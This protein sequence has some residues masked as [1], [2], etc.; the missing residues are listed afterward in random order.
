M[1][2]I[3]STT[4]FVFVG[5]VWSWDTSKDITSA[6]QVQSRVDDLQ[7]ALDIHVNKENP[8]YQF[9]D[10]TNEPVCPSMIT[11]CKT[12]YFRNVSWLESIGNATIR[13]TANVD[14]DLETR[15]D[16]GTHMAD[17][18][19][20]K[21]STMLTSTTTK[22]WK[23]GL[24]LSPATSILGLNGDVSGEYNEQYAE[25]KATT[26][27]RS[28]EKSCP[29]NMRCTIQTIT[30]EAKMPGNCFVY[31]I[32]DCGGGYDACGTF[33]T[34]PIAEKYPV[35]DILDT[36]FGPCAQF[37]DF[38]NKE[39]QRDLTKTT[40]CEITVPILDNAGKPYSHMITT[41]E[42]LQNVAARDTKKSLVGLQEDPKDAGQPPVDL[43]V[44]FVD[45]I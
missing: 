37:S 14:A 15:H 33:S 31:P 39:C 22:G 29:P 1:V 36:F 41:Q 45:D 4:L 44:E 23:V 2:A 3:R 18:V 6:Q 24:K 26:V 27:E 38:G 8:P 43:V 25:A 20:T 30:Y 28:V 11:S 40:P 12:V 21:T 42:K 13:A 9:A 35:T 10:I 17:K 5:S 34:T 7:R 16:G 32:I 19:T